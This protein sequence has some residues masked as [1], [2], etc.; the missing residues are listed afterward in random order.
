MLL[1]RLKPDLLAKLLADLRIDAAD[2]VMVGDTKGDV[3]AGKANGLATIG[4]TYGYGK[5]E[6]LAEADRICDSAFDVMSV[7]F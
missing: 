6:E 5:R 3:D 1:T 4:V 2:A 7:A